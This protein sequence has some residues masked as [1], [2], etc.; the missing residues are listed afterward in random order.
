MK[1]SIAVFL[2]IVPFLAPA[3]EGADTVMTNVAPSMFGVGFQIGPTFINPDYINNQ[4]EFVNQATNSSMRPIRDAALWSVWLSVRPKNVYNY[5]SFRAEYIS[6]TRSY[7]SVTQ[8]TDHTGANSGT[9]ETSVTT[10]YTL[11]PLSLNVGAVIPKTAAKFE[12]GF[13]YA[14]AVMNETGT[15]QNGGGYDK[16]FDGEGFGLRT[17]LQFLFPLQ[18]KYAGTID[19]GYRYLSISEFRDERGN[20]LKHFVADYSG[21]IFS[22]GLSYGM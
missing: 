14:F 4:I 16:Q 3:Q 1:L 17:S 11:Y 8:M 6:N 12:I 7:T 10:R 13:L 5:V 19:V 20:S 15:M 9:M 22:L 21:V 2:M 18:D